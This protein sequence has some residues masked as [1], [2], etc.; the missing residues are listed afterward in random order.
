V[1]SEKAEPFEST[2]QP[3]VVHHEIRDREGKGRGACMERRERDRERER[4]AIRP[5]N[6]EDTRVMNAETT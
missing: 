2:S 3:E 4:R 1:Q 6:L 5:S